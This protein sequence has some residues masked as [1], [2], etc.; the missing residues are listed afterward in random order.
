MHG[1]H[2]AETGWGAVTCI[3]MGWLAW[4]VLLSHLGTAGVRSPLRCANSDGLREVGWLGM[5]E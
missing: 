3:R 2:H 1:L 4:L 5:A